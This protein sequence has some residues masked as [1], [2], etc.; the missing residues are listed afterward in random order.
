MFRTIHK[1]FYGIAWVMALIGGLVLTLLVLML[2]LS[3]IGREA[4]DLLHSAW[5]QSTMP[6]VAQSLLDAGVGPIFGDYEFLVGGLAFAVF[7]FLG[8]CQ[9][10]AGHAT[11][12]VFTAGLSDRSRRWLQVAIEI[13]FAVALVV[14]AIQL[15]DGMNTLARRRSTTFLL[16]Y[17]LW[18]NYALSLVP[19]VLT[20]I[21]AIYMALVRLAEA[22][23]NQ[24]LVASA[25]ADH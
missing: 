6:G 7:C 5:M 3:I 21:I 2:C 18:W 11:V 22:V 1:L 24:S 12:D 17:P 20:A 4:S 13:L 14:I 9:I 25:G 15:Y 8:W 10:T 19:A 23:S 16:Q